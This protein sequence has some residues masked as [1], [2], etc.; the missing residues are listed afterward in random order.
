[1]T[2][3]IESVP[4]LDAFQNL[5]E[6]QTAS[7][8]E[9]GWLQQLRRRAFD[10]AHTIGFPT[11]KMEDFRFS[12]LSGIRNTEFKAV[13]PKVDVTPAD[14]EPFTYADLSDLQLVF[15]NGEFRADLSTLTKLPTG[16]I[17]TN[18]HQALKQHVGEMEH[19][20]GQ[21]TATDT[22]FFTAMNEALFRDG[23]V[24]YVP[25]HVKLETTIHAIFLTT[26]D[27]VPT[28]EASRSLFV[29]GEEA[30]ATIV[31][32]HASLG[33]GVYFKNTVTEVHMGTGAQV[34]HYRIQRESLQSYNVTNLRLHEDPRS[35]FRSHGFDFGGLTVR[36]NL[37]AKLDGEFCDATLNSLYLLRGKQHV[38][39][40]MWVEHVKEDIPS[41]ELY[42]GILDEEASAVFTGRLYV[43]KEAQRT[44]AKQTNQNLLLSD[45]ARINTKPQLEI[46]ADDVKCTHGATV[47]QLD[48]GALF[49]LQSRA[50][51]QEAARNLLILAFAA[52]ITEGIRIDS[53][54]ERVEHTLHERLLQDYE[55]SA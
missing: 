13:K 37:F 46:Y 45:D 52:E 42:K 20:L 31:E 43:H 5:F 4:V 55:T 39:N 17:V 24:V 29:F 53:V 22:T 23:L 25:D 40:F 7:S 26:E 33:G 36:N 11:N 3:L 35:H 8:A 21:L 51:D 27:S 50:I 12:K 54:R 14:V 6:A 41:H 30:E 32:T 38:D 15:I 44:D 19:Y 1:M 34:D 48:P 10:R 49:Y 9:A 18:L 16:V 2:T 47:G 28:F